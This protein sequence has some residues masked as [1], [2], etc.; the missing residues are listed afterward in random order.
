MKKSLFVLFFLFTATALMAQGDGEIVNINVLQRDDGT[1]TVDIFY[2]ISGVGTNYYNISLEVSFNGDNTFEQI[3]PAHFVGDIRNVQEGT[4]YHIIWYGMVSHPGIETEQ[5]QIKI[6]AD[7]V[8]GSLPFNGINYTVQPIGNKVWFAQNLQS[9]FYEN[10]EPIEQWTPDFGGPGEDDTRLFFIYPYEFA[11]NHVS[12]FSQYVVEPFTSDMDVVNAYGYHYNFA[13]VMSGNICPAG[14]RVA[15]L[16]D[17]RDLRDYA[18]NNFAHVNEDNV[19]HSFRSCR[20][21][22]SSDEGCSVTSHPLWLWDS[23]NPGNPAGTD[24]MGLSIVPAGHTSASTL[25]EMSAGIG[26]SASYWAPDFSGQGTE[27]RWVE[28]SAGWGDIIESDPNI[29][30]DDVSIGYSVRCLKDLD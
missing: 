25:E 24:D 17:W 4:G 22:I 18:I 20:E 14:W 27:M 10:G 26:V 13:T 2:D 6:I 15:T 19:A 7:Y 28:I 21:A 1:G 30:Y 9:R 16:Q 5:A 8:G 3:D 11:N 12:E 29:T 23:T